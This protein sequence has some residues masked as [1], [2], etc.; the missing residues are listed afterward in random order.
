MILK[1]QELGTKASMNNLLPKNASSPP[2]WKQTNALPGHSPLHLHCNEAK[3]RKTVSGNVCNSSSDIRSGLVQVTKGMMN[4]LHEPIP[5]W[6]CRQSIT[7]THAHSQ[8]FGQFSNESTHNQPPTCRLER[9]LENTAP[10]Q[11]LVAVCTTVHLLH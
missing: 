9:K 2:L 8:T 1:G 4:I 5:P 10:T 6:T 7:A 3:D 11:T